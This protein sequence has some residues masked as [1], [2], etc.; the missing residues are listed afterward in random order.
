MYEAPLIRLEIDN[1]KHSVLT[2]LDNYHTNIEKLVEEELER[3]VKDL[4]MS[5]IVR[6]A[7][8]R[9][10]SDSVYKYFGQGDG[11]IAVD[12]AVKEFLNNKEF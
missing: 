1:M 10:V 5:I 3:A 4:D 7:L 12:K 6:Q 9:A 2:Y 11:K 8:S